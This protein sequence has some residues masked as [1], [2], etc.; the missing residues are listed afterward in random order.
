MIFS[1]YLATQM[2]TN[3]ASASNKSILNEIRRSNAKTVIDAVCA[4][5]S[6][7]SLVIQWKTF[8]NMRPTKRKKKRQSKSDLVTRKSKKLKNQFEKM[9]RFK[10]AL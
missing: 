4:I 10:S 5:K 9:L 2:Y 6:T 1:I 7:R 3:S 8:K